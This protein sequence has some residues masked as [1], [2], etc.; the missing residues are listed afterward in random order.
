MKRKK[1]RSWPANRLTIPKESLLLRL[2]QRIM[3]MPKKEVRVQLMIKL[4]VQ[5]V[6]SLRARR[7]RSR[8]RRK[9]LKR[10]KMRKTP[11]S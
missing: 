2:P 1:R 6:V 11:K 8:S 3:M 7:K 4:P 9:L 5:Q 10:L